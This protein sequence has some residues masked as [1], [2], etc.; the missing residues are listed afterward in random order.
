MPLFLLTDCSHAFL[1]SLQCRRE[2]GRNDRGD[3]DDSFFAAASLTGA[4][5]QLITL[6]P[7]TSQLTKVRMRLTLFRRQSLL[8]VVP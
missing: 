2:T 6:V 3:H 8:M 4:A 7:N 5:Y 1:P